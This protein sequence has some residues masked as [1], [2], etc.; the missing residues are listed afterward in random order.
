[1]DRPLSSLKGRRGILLF[2]GQTACAKTGPIIERRVLYTELE[3]WDT[4]YRWK[5]NPGIPQLGSN[6]NRFKCRLF[7]SRGHTLHYVYTV[8]PVW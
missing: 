7:G 5:G 1:M 6:K 8:L 4:K 2:K 3:K